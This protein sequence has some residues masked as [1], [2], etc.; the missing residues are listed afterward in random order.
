ME[1]LRVKRKYVELEVRLN[2]SG[3]EVIPVA[4]LPAYAGTALAIAKSEEV[5]TTMHI[6]YIH[7]PATDTYLKAYF[8]R[9]GWEVVE[10]LQR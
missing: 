8:L 2:S 9:R 10:S 5:T 4:Y 3:V 7:P 1:S 6:R